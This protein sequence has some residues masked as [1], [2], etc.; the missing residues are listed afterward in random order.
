VLRWG[1]IGTLAPGSHADLIVVDRDP[2]AAPLD[3]LPGTRVLCTLL[4]G[5]AV[6]DRGG[7]PL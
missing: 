1:G 5:A 6:A 4:G 2:I 3:E 7:L